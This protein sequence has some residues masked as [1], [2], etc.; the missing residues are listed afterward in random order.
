MRAR[1][2]AW[3]NDACG[4][5]S[6]GVL[7]DVVRDATRA[8]Q[9][10][11]TWKHVTHPLLHEVQW[12]AVHPIRC[13]APRTLAGT[14]LIDA[15]RSPAV[16]FRNAAHDATRDAAGG[17]RHFTTRRRGC[18]EKRRSCVSDPAPPALINER[19]NGTAP[20][21]SIRTHRGAAGPARGRREGQGSGAATRAHSLH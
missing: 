1:P 10:L 5:A 14:Q 15:T 11:R 4:V 2:V 16:S 13:R 9:R 3:V 7:G 6:L 12:A 18:D 17:A 21:A 19:I 20:P 8:T